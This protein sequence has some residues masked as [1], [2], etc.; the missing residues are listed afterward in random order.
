M[1][2]PYFFCHYVFFLFIFLTVCSSPLKQELLL[3]SDF[4][5]FKHISYLEILYLKLNQPT[6]GRMIYF[7]TS[8]HRLFTVHILLYYV[9]SLGSC[10]P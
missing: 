8:Q 5:H 4:L 7:C 10:L 3:L 6:L 2:V 1:V 9:S